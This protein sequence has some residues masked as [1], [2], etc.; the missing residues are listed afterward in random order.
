M[1]FSR[2][3]DESC[4]VQR[5]PPQKCPYDLST[6]HLTET[7]KDDALHSIQLQQQALRFSAGLPAQRGTEFA[8]DPPA[9]VDVHAPSNQVS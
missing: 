8:H 6:T 3:T 5:N 9:A 7:F 2:L 4:S 1:Q